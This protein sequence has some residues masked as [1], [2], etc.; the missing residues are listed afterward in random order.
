MEEEDPASSSAMPALFATSVPAGGLTS[1]LQ[2]L[3][4]IIDE[5][6]PVAAEKPASSSRKRKAA[7]LGETQVELALLD[8]QPC[9]SEIV[10]RQRTDDGPKIDRQPA[11]TPM[12]VS[13]PPRT[14]VWPAPHAEK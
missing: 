1:E 14:S 13:D 5:D 4:A 2:A 3:A 10:Q 12:A 8:C 11:P 9:S 7:S 6:E